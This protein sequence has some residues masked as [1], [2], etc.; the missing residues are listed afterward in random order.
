[1]PIDS[2]EEENVAKLL[3]EK[4]TKEMELEILKNKSIEQIWQEELSELNKQY[5]I[6]RNARIKRAS[7]ETKVKKIR[8]PRKKII[9]I[10]K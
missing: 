4:E 9:K 6:Y 1:M 8:K 5:N 2:V 10:K 3:N 7:G